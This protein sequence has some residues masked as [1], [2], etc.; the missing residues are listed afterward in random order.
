MCDVK[1]LVDGLT[2]KDA[3]YAHKCLKQLQTESAAAALVYPFFDR[4]VEMLGSDN[5]YIRTRG[6]VLL[7]ANAK[8]DADCKFEQIIDGYLRHIVDDKPITARQCIQ[9]LSTIVRCKPN[10]KERI[11][12][13]LHR[14]DLSMYQDSMR[15]LV[16]KDIQQ[17][18]SA[19]EHLG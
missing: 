12:Q 18:L 3:S 10:L 5:S 9:T 1:S 16:K 6:I 17:A 19:I 4:F 7:A 14:A 15:P 13:A 8:W 2:H 11:E